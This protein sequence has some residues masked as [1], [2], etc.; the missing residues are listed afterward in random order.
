MRKIDRKQDMQLEIYGDSLVRLHKVLKEEDMLKAAHRADR[1]GEEANLN[2][3]I[4]IDF[5]T[6]TSI[7]EDYKRHGTILMDGKQA[8]IVTEPLSVVL[9]AWL[10]VKDRL[11]NI[12]CDVAEAVEN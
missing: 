6:I 2:P 11:A 8:V 12:G 4:I 9:D 7:Q 1:D 5:S 3:I 10:D